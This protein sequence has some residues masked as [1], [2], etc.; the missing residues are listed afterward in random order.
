MKDDNDEIVFDPE[1]GDLYSWASRMGAKE[2]LGEIRLQGWL[3]SDDEWKDTECNEQRIAW[4]S[5][6]YAARKVAMELLTF[7]REREGQEIDA[8]MLEEMRKLCAR[9][10]YD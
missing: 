5:A 10:A 1:T 8:D 7:A 2:V 4:W 6:W 3:V 9:V